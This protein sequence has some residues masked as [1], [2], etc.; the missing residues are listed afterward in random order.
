MKLSQ[1]SPSTGKP[2]HA[3]VPTSNGARPRRAWSSGLAL[4]VGLI[5]V[6]V[7]CG[8]FF[9]LVLA[10][11]VRTP[12][13]TLTGTYG[14][15]W[16]VNPWVGEDLKTLETLTDGTFVSHPLPGLNRMAAGFWDRGDD[17][18]RRAVDSCPRHTPIMIYVNLHGA[19]DDSGRPCLIPPGASVSDSSTWFPIHHLIERVIRVQNASDDH[20]IVLIL[21]CGRLRSYWPAGIIENRFD[22]RLSSLVEDHKRK[23]PSSQLTVLSSSR[24]GQRSLA[25]RRGDGDV[26]TRFVADGLAG[27]ADG[28]GS[29][30]T[31]GWVD[32]DELH[33]FVDSRLR[34]WSSHHRGVLQS[35]GLHRTHR[36]TP[37]KIARVGRSAKRRQV[38]MTS[39]P[40]Q[41]EIDRLLDVSR[42]LAGLQHRGAAEIN[43]HAW[44]LLQSTLHATTQSTF[45]GLAVRQSVDRLY[46]QMN[47]QMQNL[48]Q[49]IGSRNGNSDTTIDLRMHRSAAVIWETIAAQ[50][51]LETARDAVR[52]L[53]PEEP[54][55]VPMLHALLAEVDLPFWKSPHQIRQTAQTQATWFRCVAELPD[56][57]FPSAT[58]IT[59]TIDA[60]RRELAD[61]ILASRDEVSP[62]DGAKLQLLQSRVNDQCERLRQLAAAF[63]VQARSFAELPRLGPW[64][65]QAW[66]ETETSTEEQAVGLRAIENLTLAL[67]DFDDATSPW[68]EAMQAR[69]TLASERA[70]S[71]LDKWNELRIAALQVKGG[72]MHHPSGKTAG[73]LAQALHC[74]LPITPLTP[75]IEAEQSLRQWDADLEQTFEARRVEQ[76]IADTVSDDCVAGDFGNRCLATL[77]ATDRSEINAPV[78]RRKISEFTSAESRDSPHPNW[79]RGVG[80]TVD[81]RFDSIVLRFMQRKRKQRLITTANRM[82]DDFWYAPPHD[83]VPYFADTAKRLIDVADLSAQGSADW[84]A[85]KA[86]L[87]RL[88]NSRSV[89]AHSGLRLRASIQPG[90]EESTERAVTVQIKAD[91]QH[92]LLPVGTGVVSINSSTPTGASRPIRLDPE[93]LAAS[94]QEITMASRFDGEAVA[95]VAFRGHTFLCPVGGSTTAAGVSVEPTRSRNSAQL[96]IQRAM[97]A[98]NAICFVLDCSASMHESTPN[99]M[100]WDAAKV[101]SF[102]A[103]KA[104][105]LDAARAALM[106]MLRRLQPTETEIG[107]VL[108]GH[109]MAIGAESQGPLLQK[110]YYNRFPFPPTLQPYEDVELVLPTGR[111]DGTQIDAVHQRLDATVPWGQTPLHLAIHL[112]MND[113]AGRGTDITKDVIVITDGQ[114]YQFNPSADAVIPLDRLVATAKSE[115]IRVH[116]IGFGL[117]DAEAVTAIKQFER[118]AEGSGGK[119]YHEVDEATDLLRELE[120]FDDTGAFSIRVAGSE[121]SSP[122]FGQVATIPDV[123]AD[124]TELEIVVAGQKHVVPICPGNHLKFAVD[125]TG[126]SLTSIPYRAGVPQYVSLST[127]SGSL[128]SAR[129]ALHRTNRIGDDLKIRFSIQGSNGLVPPRPEFMWF[130]VNCEDADGKT[131]RIYRTSQVQWV[132]HTSCPVGE[133]RCLRWPAEATEFSFRAWC[134]KT[135]PQGQTVRLHVTASEAEALPGHPGVT[136]ELRHTDRET[137]LTLR[138]DASDRVHEK[139]PGPNRTVRSGRL[140]VQLNEASKHGSTQWYDDDRHMSVHSFTRS[141]DISRDNASHSVV[142]SVRG[143]DEAVSFWIG[144]ESEIKDASASTDGPLR[145]SVRSMRL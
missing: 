126:R 8:F 3:P 76:D 123:I 69:I 140:A 128:V 137:R 78:V 42:Q 26:F 81:V 80:L 63:K 34:C 53:K 83:G 40:E 12:I 20:P 51:S 88:L 59:L 125:E 106:E 131:S 85:E 71:H 118:I 142:D 61:L 67:A 129:L 16:D 86:D 97:E 98:R 100:A 120:G 18:L 13:I 114:N 95:K 28:S 130:E 124:N 17:V 110:R 145:Q 48:A 99:E 75:I 82:L 19:V 4:T 117:P 138:Y 32:S 15:N 54:S 104:T 37:I 21:E 50:P 102:G 87:V 91:E 122:L 109:R 127:T 52:D 144:S 121:V 90:F 141:H 101:S 64:I 22:E 96:T 84:T 119:T 70:S 105:K 11:P 60:T 43:P 27:A 25:T 107:L 29:D 132:D 35:P 46:S 72:P 112:A 45:G 56:D 89:A 33:R 92:H 41:R 134:C 68:D 1:R 55:P 14:S 39:A 30:K 24:L 136:Y 62:L 6:F 115:Q 74:R 111:F 58:R 23:Y 73:S 116:I 9:S 10:R 36:S 93:S 65:D 108:Y 113:M 94:S 135:K 2:N 49:Q 47:R 44:S 77:L 139:I 143:A 38:E 7:L 5:G 66:I 79:R 133:I 57:L 103:K 31:D